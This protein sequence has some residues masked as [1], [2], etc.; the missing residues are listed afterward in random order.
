MFQ[1][2]RFNNDLDLQAYADAVQEQGRKRGL[3]Q[4]PTLALVIVLPVLLLAR[5][6]VWGWRKIRPT[7]S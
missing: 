2:P 5:L 7:K 1:D 6:A 3:A 4:V